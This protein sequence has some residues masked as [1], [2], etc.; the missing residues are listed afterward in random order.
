MLLD[1]VLTKEQIAQAALVLLDDVGLDRLTVR[2]V[3]E[4]LGVQHGALYWHVHDKH[5]LLDEVAEAILKQ[6]FKNFLESSADKSWEE[7]LKLIPAM[8]RQAMLA[9]R[10][11][12]KVIANAHALERTP[13]FVDVATLLISRMCEAGFDHK[14]A[15]V[16][17]YTTVS[18][19]MG[20]TLQE[21]E[22]M[23]RKL[24]SHKNLPKGKREI[25][26]TGKDSNGMFVDGLT[27]ITANV[28]SHI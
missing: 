5:E 11:G 17:A 16:L 8:L 24:D 28:A 15:T 20:F 23:S 6:H 7:L 3:A 21:Q 25:L 22:A 14:T 27:S 19:T 10:D 26:Y 2:R 4:S 9:H 18:Y 12:A 1:M 13:T